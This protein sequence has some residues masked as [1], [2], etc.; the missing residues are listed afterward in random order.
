MSDLL[1]GT[2]DAA[3]PR[4]R[5]PGTLLLASL[6]TQYGPHQYDTES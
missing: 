2:Q 3:R 1:S 4:R 5:R 6:K